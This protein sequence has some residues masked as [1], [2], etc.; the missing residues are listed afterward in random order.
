MP[1]IPTGKAG[2]RL[3]RRRFLGVSAGA[4]AGF[5]RHDIWTGAAAGADSKN[6]KLHVASIGVGNQGTWNGK[7]AAELGRVVAGCDLHLGRAT[8]FAAAHQCPAYQD[9]RKLLHAKTS[10]PS[11]LPHPIIGT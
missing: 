11:P 2:L 6:E 7:W 1:A 4:R 10:T 9:Y 8:T 5:W 3:D